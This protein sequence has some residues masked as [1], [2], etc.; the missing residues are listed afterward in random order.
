[1]DV[2][3]CNF[4][5]LGNFEAINDIFGGMEMGDLVR[6]ATFEAVFKNKTFTMST[7]CLVVV[8]YEIDIFEK[9]F[10]SSFTE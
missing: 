3:D 8:Q 7:E 6:A 4:G 1:M 2:L 5:W 9:Q 10:F